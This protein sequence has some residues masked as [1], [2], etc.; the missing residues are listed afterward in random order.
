MLSFDYP[1]AGL[2]DHLAAHHNG[3]LPL[4]AYGSLLNAASAVRT[5]PG[6]RGEECRPANAVGLVRVF[7]Y[8]LTPDAI[9][10]YGPGP[11]PQHV[12]ALGV[13]AT[14]LPTDRVNGLVYSLAAEDLKGFRQRETGYRLAEVSITPWGE[15][16]SDN[17]SSKAFA[18][19]YLGPD[20]PQLLPHPEYLVVC[21]K[22]AASF[23]ESFRDDFDRTTFLADGRRLIDYLS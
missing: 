1:W 8:P 20:D 21:R 5:M 13:R 16:A 15:G 19:E 22:G 9:E 18:L 14:G 3:R 11:T 23:G 4:F 12:A 10:R 17:S 7:N 6:W 2:E